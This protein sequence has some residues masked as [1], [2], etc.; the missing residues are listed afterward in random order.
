MKAILEYDQIIDFCIADAH[1]EGKVKAI[2]SHAVDVELT[3]A[4]RLSGTSNVLD[5]GTMF[6]VY[7]KEITFT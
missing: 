5:S 4:L 2:Y 1:G 7:K 3:Q 6:L